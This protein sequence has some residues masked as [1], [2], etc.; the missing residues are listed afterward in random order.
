MSG[1]LIALIA[2]AVCVSAP[3]IV[4]AQNET[5]ARAS[6]APK[7]KRYCETYSDIRS[8]LSGTRRCMSEA[9]REALQ[10]DSRRVVDRIQTMKATSAH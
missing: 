10:Q 3:A 2:A 6:K 4:V 7:T 9:E 5:G 8:R 1:K